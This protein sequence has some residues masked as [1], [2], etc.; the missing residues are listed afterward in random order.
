MPTVE[1]VELGKV[2]D[3]ERVVF[4]VLMNG[5]RRSAEQAMDA[6]DGFAEVLAG[7]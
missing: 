7:E 3:G 4:S 1:R 6:L 5:F 2:G